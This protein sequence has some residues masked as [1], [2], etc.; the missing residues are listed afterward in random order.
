VPQVDFSAAKHN[1]YCLH[2]AIKRGLVNSCHDCSDGG[3]AVALAEKAFAGNLGAHLDLS[4]VPV[5]GQL[6]DLTILFSE[7]NSRFLVT[8]SPQQKREF[9]AVM[10]GCEL[11]LIGQVLAEPQFLVYSQSGA[12]II[13]TEIS[14]LKTAW[15][16]P[17]EWL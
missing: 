14:K 7:S 12:K 8:V 3:L 10:L 13:E 9:E 6:D 2:E 17:L 1:F 11:S 5:K 15:Q 4:L 16:K